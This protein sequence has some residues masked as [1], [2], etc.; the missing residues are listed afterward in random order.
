[1]VDSRAMEFDR[2]TPEDESD[3]RLVY[4]EAWYLQAELDTP[5]AK[6]RA[7][8][9][10]ADGMPEGLILTGFAGRTFR[11]AFPGLGHALCYSCLAVVTRSSMSNV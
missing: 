1:M 6:C 2:G 11:T 10:I 8:C 3:G 7:I 4:S 9:T 5:L